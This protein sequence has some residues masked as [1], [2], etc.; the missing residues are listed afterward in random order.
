M[1]TLC[2]VI[3]SVFVT[4]VIGLM[5]WFSCQTA[6]CS[7]QLP[8]SSDASNQPSITLAWNAQTDAIV[9]GV[10]IY[11]GSQP[12]AY[13]NKINC[14]KTNSLA[15]YDLPSG[16]AYYF[17]AT[18]YSAAGAE[19]PISFEVSWT[20]YLYT[21]TNC[22]VK[23]LTNGTMLAALTNPPGNH[24]YAVSN[25]VLTEL[26]TPAQ[27]YFGTNKTKSLVTLNVSKQLFFKITP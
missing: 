12:H 20:N 7:I 22:I 9:S 19:S 14:G 26:Q 24:F 6:L 27:N 16:S 15:L 2:N 17:A 8:M 10:N 21:L 25:G 1:K 23:F 11:C 18:T 3:I 13:T 5:V 4:A